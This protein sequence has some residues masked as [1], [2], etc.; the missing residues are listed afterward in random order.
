[1]FCPNQ[2]WVMV[3]DWWTYLGVKLRWKNEIEGPLPSATEGRTWL[4]FV[5]IVHT[6]PAY[7]EVVDIRKRRLILTIA[8]TA[9]A[10][11]GYQAARIYLM[12]GKQ[13]FNCR[14]Y[15]FNFQT[16]FIWAVPLCMEL[17]SWW[18]CVNERHS[19]I[20]HGSGSICAGGFLDRDWAKNR[21]PTR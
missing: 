8:M 6:L 17:P 16:R 3:C 10:S 20:L 7:Q 19:R 21:D 13:M 2:S 9:F 12:P 11:K 14:H 18:E 1:M 5:G 15:Q 4:E